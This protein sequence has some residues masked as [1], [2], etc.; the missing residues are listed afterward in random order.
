M[1]KVKESRLSTWSL[2]VLGV[3][4]ITSCTSE[5]DEDLFL[6]KNVKSGVL[7][8]RQSAEAGNVKNSSGS[9]TRSGSFLNSSIT[10]SAKWS[11]YT[12]DP[13]AAAQPRGYLTISVSGGVYSFS[14]SN[15]GGS[16]SEAPI[17]DGEYPWSSG[18]C[19]NV[20]GGNVDTTM[21][22]SLEVLGDNNAILSW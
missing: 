22:V 15:S 6:R 13:N 3:F 11:I 21:C 14:P 19:F 20:T 9:K 17:W 7:I 18:E 16:S 4:F 2:A 10:V 5:S 12:R 1:K 8:L